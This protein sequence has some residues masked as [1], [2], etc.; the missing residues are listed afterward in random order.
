MFLSP[1]ATILIYTGTLYPV[2]TMFSS[3]QVSAHF[4]WI[5]WIHWMQQQIVKRETSNDC[6]CLGY[7]GP[8]TTR[9]FSSQTPTT[10][11]CRGYVRLTLREWVT[12]INVQITPGE[13]HSNK[14]NLPFWKCNF[15]LLFYQQI[16]EKVHCIQSLI[17][18]KLWGTVATHFEHSCWKYYAGYY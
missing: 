6:N 15:S 9:V 13:K 17:S 11:I 12:L 4:H 16:F 5:G 10:I 3:K 14:F 1:V 7:Q 2:A 8:D 18:A